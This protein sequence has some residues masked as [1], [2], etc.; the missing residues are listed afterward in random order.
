MTK[1]DF[2]RAGKCNITEWFW[3][4]CTKQ[5]CKTVDD[6]ETNALIKQTVFYIV[7]QGS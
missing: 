6:L 1:Q 4:S 2:I 7:L 3:S 5:Q